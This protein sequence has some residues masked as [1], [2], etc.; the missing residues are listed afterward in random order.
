[1]RTLSGGEK[2]EGGG[3][4]E[5]AKPQPVDDAESVAS[6]TE[7]TVPPPA[8]LS[9][10]FALMQSNFEKLSTRVS[11]LEFGSNG[12][13]CP[14]PQFP[15][16]PITLPEGAYYP[17]SDGPPICKFWANGCCTRGVKC[18]FFHPSPCGPCFA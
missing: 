9:V 12:Y 10:K 16:P 11:T 17:P 18:R 2:L 15:F 13:Y 1:M 7:I 4:L 14:I 6:D 3:K 5:A 8:N